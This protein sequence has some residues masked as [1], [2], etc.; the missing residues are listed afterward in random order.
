MLQVDQVCKKLK[1]KKLKKKK[2]NYFFF[3]LYDKSG[4]LIITICLHNIM[5]IM[6]LSEFDTRRNVVHN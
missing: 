5:I 6:V 1:K 4:I 3:F 2:K